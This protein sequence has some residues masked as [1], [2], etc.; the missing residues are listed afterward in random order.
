VFIVP[1]RERVA[2]VDVE[3]AGDGDAVR[4]VTAADAEHVD[5]E[6]PEVFGDAIQLVERARGTDHSVVAEGASESAG[7]AGVAQITAATRIE[8]DAYSCHGRD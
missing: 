5:L 8:D 3:E 4:A 6:L 7:C 2:L 1:P